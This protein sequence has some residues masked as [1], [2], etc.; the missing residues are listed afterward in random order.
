MD[1]KQ[2]LGGK[3]REIRKQKN[4]SQ[5]NLAIKSWIHRTYLSWVER[6]LKNISVENIEKV[7]IALEVEI[8]D[9][10]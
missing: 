10:F 3:I 8:R 2:K 1:I 6:W 7:A 5:L 4:I 9:L